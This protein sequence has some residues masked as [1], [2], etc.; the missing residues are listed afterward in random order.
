MRVTNLKTENYR[1]LP[2]LDYSPCAGVNLIC[3]ENGRGKTNLI[4]SIWLFTGCRSFRSVKDTDVINFNEKA[5]KVNLQF[6]AKNREQT[7]EIVIEERRKATLN[8]VR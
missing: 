2:A 8:G 5:A 3:G 7:A 6:F 4:E 1:N